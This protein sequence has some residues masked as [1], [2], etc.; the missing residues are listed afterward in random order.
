V[1]RVSSKDREQRLAEALRANL[2]R[3]KAQARAVAR[4]PKA[5][6]EKASET[7]GAQPPEH[8]DPAHKRF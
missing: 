3:R 6:G 5:G 4:D 8:P 1:S 2:K 7:D